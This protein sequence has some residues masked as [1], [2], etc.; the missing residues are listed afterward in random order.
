MH[1]EVVRVKPATV[2]ARQIVPEDLR[3]GCIAFGHR[4]AIV[5][6]TKKKAL[7]KLPI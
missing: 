1:V 2:R 3:S 4:A 6:A 5:P 7:R